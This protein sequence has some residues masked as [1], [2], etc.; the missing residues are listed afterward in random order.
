MFDKL[1]G[2]STIYRMTNRFFPFY[3]L[4]YE[5]NPFRALTDEEWVEVAV[6]PTQVQEV[7]D[8]GFS[9]LQVLGEKGYG[10]TTLLLYLAA[11]QR[12]AGRRVAY[13]RIPED[14]RTFQTALDN[15]DCFLLDEAQRLTN[16]ERK[17]LMKQTELIQLIV[18][19]HEDFN[20]VFSVHKRPIM[21]V[22]LGVNGREH[23][24]AVLNRRLAYF[25]LK[26]SSRAFISDEMI[27][28]VWGEFG[29]DIRAVEQ[30]LY[31]YYQEMAEE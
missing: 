11:Q 17:R 14:G 4:G 8:S 13:E 23:L 18:S 12:Y 21:T 22:N 28:F 27:D 29:R 31:E 20:G 30:F 3:S 6:V 2:D 5:C 10:K 19:S 15:L 16:K 26:D 24:R 25:S 9:N 7:L 1:L